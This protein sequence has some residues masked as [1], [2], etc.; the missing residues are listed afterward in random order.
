[1]L[2][3]GL[4]HKG[5]YQRQSGWGKLWLQIIIANGAM[6][7]FLFVFSPNTETWFNW[8]LLER[9]P[10]LLGFVCIAM[11][12]YACSLLLLGFRPKHLKH[13]IQNH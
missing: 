4:K 8:D 13:N 1:M 7:A 10:Y 6:A 12:I 5:I 3:Q 2:Y 9:V 11:S